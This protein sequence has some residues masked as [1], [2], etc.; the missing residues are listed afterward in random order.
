M[1]DHHP[2][3]RL[4]R[5]A[6]DG[7]EHD[8]AVDVDRIVRGGTARGRTLRR[9]RR[10]GTALAAAA[11]V[12]VI[13]VAA[14]VGPTLLGGEA[15]TA[16]EYADQPVTEPVTTPTPTAEPTEAP[17]TPPAGQ[18]DALVT[19]SAYD[20]PG[21]VGREL[22]GTVSDPLTQ[23]PYGVSDERQDKMVHF[24]YDGTLTT[25]GIERADGLA[26]C[27]ALVDPAD[28]PDGQPAG[29]CET[30]DGVLLLLHDETADGV[31]SRSVW[32]WRHGYVVSLVSYDSPDGRAEPVAPAPPIS[33]ADAVRLVTSE[34]WFG[35]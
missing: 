33:E 8:L 22:G 19:V 2:A 13:G 15:R 3:S 6:T 25:V 20:V 30:R 7:L 11:V 12:G 34:V 17:V 18:V 24:R 26:S 23:A 9:R 31:T 1:N 35:G 14:G 16:P 4:L 5:D 28:Q 21:I 29:R 27:E 32:A 10:V